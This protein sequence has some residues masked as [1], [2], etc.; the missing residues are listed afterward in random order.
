MQGAGDELFA[1]ARLAGD[2]HGG[3]GIRHLLDD[4]EDLL[5]V[6]G[7]AD[8]AEASW[9]R[10]VAP[11][12]H[13]RQLGAW[14]AACQLIGLGRLVD[15]LADLCLLEG[16]FDVV[17][18][19]ELD[20]LDRRIDGA[21]RGDDDDGDLRVVDGHAAEQAHAIESRH[22]EIGD[23]HLHSPTDESE[24]LFAVGRLDHFVALA[25]KDGAQHLT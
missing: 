1:R 18:G 10:A 25:R 15:D 13:G 7:D 4:G 14:G 20:R 24:R 9:R 12:G 11:R 22:A 17:E 23:D 8:E 19:P 16:F 3:G 5:Q 6:L 2:E 21:V